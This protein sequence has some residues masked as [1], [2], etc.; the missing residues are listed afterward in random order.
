MNNLT[1]DVIEAV[2]SQPMPPMTQATAAKVGYRELA[3][4]ETDLVQKFREQGQQLDTLCRAISG[5]TCDGR[6]A[7]VAKTHFQQGLMAAVRSITKPAF[8]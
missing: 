4:W 6:W 7:S 5:N 2:P 3:D 8:F 1:G